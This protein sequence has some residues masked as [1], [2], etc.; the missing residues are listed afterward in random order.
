MIAVDDNKKELFSG[1]EDGL[2]Y[3][4]DSKLKSH[5]SNM[6]SSHNPNLDTPIQ[7]PNFDDTPN[8][9]DTPI[10]PIE[11]KQN[12]HETSY[13][14]LNT[15]SN[16]DANDTINSCSQFM[17]WIR[18]EAEFAQTPDPQEEVNNS[19]SF[20][21]LMNSCICM[22]YI[23]KRLIL[24]RKRQFAISKRQANAF[25]RRIWGIGSNLL[26]SPVPGRWIPAQ[27]SHIVS[28]DVIRIELQM[29]GQIFQKEVGRNHTTI[30]PYPDQINAYIQH[31]PNYFL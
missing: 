30:K 28:S 18:N 16:V 17:R 9:P 2:H 22:K 24:Q 5:Q 8:T 7:I 20:F 11:Y 1:L 23:Q 19:L 31:G 29:V 14:A 10:T 13:A 3:P 15:A 6:E 12:E 26:F 25:L 21:L 4:D 27:I